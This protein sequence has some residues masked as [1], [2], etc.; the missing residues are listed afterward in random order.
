MASKKFIGVTFGKFILIVS[1]VK[2]VYGHDDSWPFNAD[3]QISIS[4]D[5]EHPILTGKAWND[6]WGG[7]TC[8]DITSGDRNLLNE[9]NEACSA[10]DY[11]C[12]RYNFDM[13]HK[14]NDIVETLA[15]F[16][17]GSNVGKVF[18]SKAVVAAMNN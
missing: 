2:E 16:C 11:H 5:R 9:I 18:T 10:F 6:G 12:D 15:M 8:I 13:T 1:N 17:T 7:E 14:L 4:P 3:F